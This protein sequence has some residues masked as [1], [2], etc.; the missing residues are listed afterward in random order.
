MHA[1][2]ARLGEGGFLLVDGGANTEAAW[3]ALDRG[4]REVAGGWERVTLH[5]VT[6]MH[7]DHL[8]LAARV[9]AAAGAPLLMGRLDA[10]RAAHADAHPEEEAKYRRALLRENGAPAETV[11]LQRAAPNPLLA[12]AAADVTLDGEGRA[13]PGAAEWSWLAT[14]GHTAGH[15]SLFRSSDRTLI[16]GDAVL[17]AITPTLGVNRQRPDPVG[18]YLEALTRVAALRPQRVLPGHG[19][20]LGDPAE[21]IR[22][23]HESTLGEGEAVQRLLQDDPRSAW[24][25]AGRRYAGRDLPPSARMQALRETRAHLDRLSATERARRIPLPGGVVGFARG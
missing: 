15:V 21:R 12:F 2:L 23:L 14:P 22:F 11:A 16:A 19:D 5:L 1:Y 10:E 7:I 9:R 25:I 17:P 6:H 18:D 24:E 3:V 8:G 20:P 13:V 4:V